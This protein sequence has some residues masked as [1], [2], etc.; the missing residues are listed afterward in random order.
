MKWRL[1]RKP[2]PFKC[3]KVVLFLHQHHHVTTLNTLELLCIPTPHQSRKVFSLGV[4]AE[5]GVEEV[6]IQLSPRSHLHISNPKYDA[7]P[8]H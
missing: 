6:G 2:H 7:V 5:A 3:L 1:L 8:F 4:E